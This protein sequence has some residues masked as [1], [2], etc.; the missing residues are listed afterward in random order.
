MST[1]SSSLAE[2]ADAVTQVPLVDGSTTRFVNFDY[3]AS[4]PPL[5]SVH[6]VVTAA[7][8]HYAS[9]HRGQ[10]YL[11]RMSTAAYERARETIADRTGAR[12]NDVVVFTRNT[13]DALILL[14]SA[15]PGRV[16]HLDIEHHANLL[17]WRRGEWSAVVAQETLEATLDALDRELARRPAALVTV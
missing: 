13:T 7:M 9:I 4:A 14:A 6:R 10:S 12:R 11:S 16:V 3:A 17:P 8:S 15:T 5:A 1:S 2:L